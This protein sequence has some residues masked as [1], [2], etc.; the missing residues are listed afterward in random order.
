M[1]QAKEFEQRES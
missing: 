1:S